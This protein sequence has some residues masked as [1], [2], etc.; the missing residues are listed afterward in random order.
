MDTFERAKDLYLKAQASYDKKDLSACGSLISELKIALVECTS[1][2][3]SAGSDPSTKEHCLARSALE[4]AVFYSIATKDI[5]SFERYMK[6]L[7]PYYQDYED[8]S[9]STYKEQ[10]TGL[11][12]LFLLAKNEVG[13]FHVELEKTHRGE[14][15]YLVLVT[16]EHQVTLQPTLTFY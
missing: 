8:K 10:M 13:K 14:D 4:L 12:L 11:Y 15:R 5:D 2:L 16:Q 1:F 7:K 6:Q 9:T 3:P